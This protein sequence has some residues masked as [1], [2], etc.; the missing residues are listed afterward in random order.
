[1]FGEIF[2]IITVLQFPPNESF[3]SRVN[4]ESLKGMWL[5]AFF[6]DFNLQSAFIQFPKAKS[7][8]LI[9]APSTNHYPLLFVFEAHSDPAKSIRDILPYQISALIPQS[10]SLYSTT[11]YNTACDLD[12][13]SLAEVG[14]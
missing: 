5:L 10:L 14:S 3:K 12:E 1:M 13:C 2:A 11:T 8:Q 4:F 9:L 6:F 7:D